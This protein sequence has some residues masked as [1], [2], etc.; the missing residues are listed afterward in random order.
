MPWPAQILVDP[1]GR[2]Y[3]VKM[4]GPA[5]VVKKNREP[6]VKMIKSIGK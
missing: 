1:N 6:F 3:F 4:I 5:E 2:K